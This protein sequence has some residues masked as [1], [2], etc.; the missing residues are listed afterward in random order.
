MLLAPSEWPPGGEVR[1]DGAVYRPVVLTARMFA[2]PDEGRWAPVR[3]TMR[4]LAAQHGDENV[5][6]VVWFG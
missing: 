4:E 2:P 3:Q 5:R 6:L 1:L